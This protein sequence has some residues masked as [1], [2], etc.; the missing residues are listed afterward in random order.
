MS[1][2]SSTASFAQTWSAQVLTAPP[3]IAPA[4]SYT[5]PQ[6]VAGEEDALARG[7]LYLLVRDPAGAN[8]LATCALGFRDPALPSGVWACPNADQMLAVAG[9]YA[10]LV[11]T[12]APQTC[13]HLPLRP[14][15]RV[16]P[17][18][19]DNLLLLAGLHTIAAINAG[20]L[21]WQTTRLSHEGLTLDRVDDGK[22][23]GTGWD[24]FADRDVE[25]CVDLANGE[26]VEASGE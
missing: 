9:G 19:A 14:V 7:A 10:Y 3:L 15:V 18:P 25:F 16:L 23:Y 4:R 24:M 8:F 2:A 5:Y 26:T 1:D 13:V 6:Q 12:R 21:A 20:D 22:L 11:D 17:A